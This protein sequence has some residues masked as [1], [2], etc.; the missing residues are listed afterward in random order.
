MVVGEAGQGRRD[1]GSWVRRVGKRGDMRR[2]RTSTYD[3]RLES[4]DGG[5]RWASR[6]NAEAVHKRRW[7]RNIPRIVNDFR[8]SMV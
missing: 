6:G 2:G 8:G 5:T 3:A 4:V 1:T 7:W